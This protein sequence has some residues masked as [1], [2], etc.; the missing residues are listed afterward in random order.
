MV[1]CKK[2]ARELRKIQ[3]SKS[4]VTKKKKNAVAGFE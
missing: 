4:A 2:D 1:K 3:I